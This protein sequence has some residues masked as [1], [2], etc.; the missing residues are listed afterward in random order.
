MSSGVG[1][2]LKARRAELTPRDVGL[3]EPEEH[4]R[5][6]G[7]RREE[8]AQ[9]ASISVDYYTRLEQ[10]RV[11]ASAAVLATLVRALRLDDTQQTYL[12]TLAG[13]AP[14]RP[15]RRSA[16]RVRPAM[17]RL[18]DQLTG[19]PALVLGHRLDI[20]A[21]NR[22]ASALYT[23]FDALPAS[24]RNY[25]RLVFT[26]PGVRAMH[27]DWAEAASAGVAVL[28]MEAAEDPQD[29]ALAA[30][31]GELA[32]QDNDF[33]TWWAAHHATDAGFGVKRYR[34]PVVGDLTLDCDMWAS[35]DGSNQRL[36]VLTAEPG[37]PSHE[38]LRILSSWHAPVS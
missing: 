35:P 11:A 36:M 25:V 33:R 3:P 22:L 13:K 5:V 4:R 1:D 6:A 24:R 29:A 9:L 31:V 23:D 30:L 2:F 21:W 20:L 14:A 28:R 10:G 32:V 34:H 18:L 26:D 7:L 12:Y 8:V 27:L 19:A 17:R 38:A 16:Q 37:S 15:R